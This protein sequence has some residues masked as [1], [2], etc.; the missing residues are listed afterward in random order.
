MDENVVYFNYTIRE[1]L[2]PT[3]PPP[4][5]SNPNNNDTDNVDWIVSDHDK[6]DTYTHCRFEA[7]AV[8]G[9]QKVLVVDSDEFMFCPSAKPTYPAQAAFIRRHITSSK[10]EGIDQLNLMMTTLYN[11]TAMNPLDCVLEKGR[12]NQSFFSCFSSTQFLLMQS[13][14]FV[15]VYTSISRIYLPDISVF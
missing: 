10:L 3:E 11:A 8:Y 9:I 14:Q 2:V 7:N 6:T 12:N 5:L 1:L 15:K 13:T 4:V